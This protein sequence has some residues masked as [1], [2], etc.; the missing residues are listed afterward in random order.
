MEGNKVKPAFQGCGNCESY[1]KAHGGHYC[2]N[3]ESGSGGEMLSPF[4]G[5]ADWSMATD[6]SIYELRWRMLAIVESAELNGLGPEEARRGLEG[7]GGGLEETCDGL[8][9]ANAV[10]R[11]NITAIRAEKERLSARE[12]AA[13]KR[14]GMRKETIK[15]MMGSAGTRCLKTALYTYSIRKN[16][17]GVKF[18]DES[19]VP[20]CYMLPQPPKP[21]KLAIA[22]A[23]KE[24]R[25]VPGA[26]LERTESL[27]VT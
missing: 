6:V 5:C 18:D 22:Y 27:V 12:D 17:P 23:L 24:G 14:I 2:G 26:R 21:D 10:D 13:E 25:D 16:G 7:L 15:Q 11:G 8:A 20:E 4:D 3:A 1:R 19:E 9:A